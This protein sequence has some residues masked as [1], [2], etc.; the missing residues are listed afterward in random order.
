[1]LYAWMSDHR[2]ARLVSCRVVW[3]MHSPN[4]TDNLVPLLGHSSAPVRQAAG[5]AIAAAMAALP[6][7]IEATFSLLAE[8][9]AVLAPSLL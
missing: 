9:V 3:G 8:K 4:Y 2:W 7:T 1:M 6:D 5:K